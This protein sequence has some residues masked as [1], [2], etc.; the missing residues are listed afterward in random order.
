MQNEENSACKS[1]ESST[2]IHGPHHHPVMTTDAAE[3]QSV[4]YLLATSAGI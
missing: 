3:L 2:E 4:L 1:R